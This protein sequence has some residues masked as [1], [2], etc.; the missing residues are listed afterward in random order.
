MTRNFNWAALLDGESTDGESADLYEALTDDEKELVDRLD[1][2]ARALPLTHIRA[3]YNLSVD[4]NLESVVSVVDSYESGYYFRSVKRGE[5]EPIPIDWTA[6]PDGDSFTVDLSWCGMFGSW[7]CGASYEA[8]LDIIKGE[9]STEG[10]EHLLAKR[11]GSPLDSNRSNLYANIGK[12]NPDLR[13]RLN[14][15]L[16]AHLQREADNFKTPVD[17]DAYASRLFETLEL[18]A[19]EAYREEFSPS[20]NELVRGAV[21]AATPMPTGIDA[22]DAILGGGLVP[23]VSVLAGDPGAGKTALAV[24]MLL[25]AAHKCGPDE[26]VVYFMCDQ[27]GAYEIAKRLASVSCAIDTVADGE[28]PVAASCRLSD[29]A[30]WTDDELSNGAKICNEITNGRVV[31]VSLLDGSLKKLKDKLGAMERQGRV[32]Y[33]LIV[34]DYYQLLRDLDD[35]E[36]TGESVATSAEFASAVITT[37]RN[38]ANCNKVPFLLIGMFNKESIQRHQKGGDPEL[39]DLLGSVDIPYQADHVIALTNTHNGSGIV[40]LADMKHR[41]AGNESQSSRFSKLRLDG[42]H[43]YFSELV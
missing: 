5:A 42:E 7:E 23:G 6:Q 26:R 14:D 43:G 11:Q 17:A 34:I 39:T 29:A 37:L 27:G 31:L 19:L 41:H 22:L 13:D 21:Q 2:R 16:L 36:S 40:H 30:R 24:Q 35:Y 25:Y 38:W 3:N 18:E 32:K 20:L 4:S 10:L 33:R 1:Y 9:A 12:V 8:I 28:D 15:L